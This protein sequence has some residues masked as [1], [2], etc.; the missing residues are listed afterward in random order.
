M[1]R[2]ESEGFC[3][4][5]AMLFHSVTM[6]QFQ[7]SHEDDLDLIKPEINKSNQNSDE[8]KISVLTSRIIKMVGFFD[9]DPNKILDILI[10]YKIK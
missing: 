10:G 7:T 5:I 2:E 1:I 4:L 6:N 8:F 9:L 3:R